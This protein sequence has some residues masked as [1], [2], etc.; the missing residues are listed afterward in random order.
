V[1][2]P[3]GSICAVTE[4]SAW[5]DCSVS[6]GIGE[7]KRTRYYKSDWAYE[8]C[9][10]HPNALELEQTIACPESEDVVCDREPKVCTD[11]THWCSAV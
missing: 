4:W 6:C 11:A 3:P 9:S 7:K 8:R 2:S 1:H 10:H 5:S